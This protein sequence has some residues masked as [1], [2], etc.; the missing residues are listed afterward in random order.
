[1]RP[2]RSYITWFSQRTG[3][4]LLCKA[5]ESTG[6]AGKPNEWLNDHETFDLFKTYNVSTPEALQQQLWELGTTPNG[7]FGLKLAMYEPHNS[8][9]LDHFRLLSGCPQPPQGR[10]AV[11][12]YAFP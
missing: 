7:V 6:L 2:T 8:R 10:A 11:W 12:E 4:T 3:S 1:M 5:L 9:M